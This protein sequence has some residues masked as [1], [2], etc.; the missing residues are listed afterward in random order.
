MAWRDGPGRR[1]VRPPPEGDLSAL[2]V[3]TAGRAGR[4]WQNLSAE[5]E[6]QSYTINRTERRRRRKAFILINKTI[7]YLGLS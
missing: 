5:T 7:Y 3:G 1:D 4:W 2:F 6:K